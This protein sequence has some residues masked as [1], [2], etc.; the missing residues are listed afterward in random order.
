M[1]VTLFVVQFAIESDDIRCSLCRRRELASCYTI[2]GI[3]TRA[4]GAARGTCHHLGVRGGKLGRGGGGPRGSPTVAGA[5]NPMLRHVTAV[6]WAEDGYTMRG[7]RGRK[8]EVRHKGGGGGGL[9]KLS[10]VYQ[11]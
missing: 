8:F 5:F 3:K 2:S 4:H 11:V 7:P 1:I 6:E 10:D 9:P